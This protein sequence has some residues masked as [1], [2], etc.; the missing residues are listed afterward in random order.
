MRDIS[1]FILFP[2][3]IL[4][5]AGCQSVS[6]SISS[7]DGIPHLAAEKPVLV[8]PADSSTL[9]IAGELQPDINECLICHS[10][11]D[12]LIET[13]DPVEETGESES[14]GVG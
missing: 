10:N 6:A 14:K 3:V 7:E 11:K 13:A 9:E 2:A 8:V 5:L 1:R 4:L 12:R